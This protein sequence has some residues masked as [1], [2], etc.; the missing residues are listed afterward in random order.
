MHGSS[1]P[2]KPWLFL[3]QY[4]VVT[5]NA[6]LKHSMTG[7]ISKKYSVQGLELGKGRQVGCTG[8]GRQ[9]KRGGQGTHQW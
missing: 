7:P 3:S 6:K 5:G 8:E 4:V 2:P 1:R 9:Q